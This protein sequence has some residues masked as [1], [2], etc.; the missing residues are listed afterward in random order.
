M[1]E[2]LGAF[3]LLLYWLTVIGVEGYQNWIPFSMSSRLPQSKRTLPSK[4]E[5][6]RTTFSN[7]SPNKRLIDHKNSNTRFLDEKIVHTPQSLLKIPQNEG[8]KRSSAKSSES[9]GDSLMAINGLR[10][11]LRDSMSDGWQKYVRSR[12]AKYR[13]N[14]IY[15]STKRTRIPHKPPSA[16]VQKAKPK[17]KAR[18]AALIKAKNS[19]TTHKLKDI[20]LGRC[21]EYKFTKGLQDRKD[22]E[23]NKLWTMFAKSFMYKP[24]CKP[25]V[26]LYEKFLDHIDEDLPHDRLGLLW[27]G[28]RELAHVIASYTKK[29]V[30][31]EDTLPGYLVNNLT[32]C[33]SEK[34]PG[35]EYKP[36]PW[37]CRIQ[38]D[39]WR[40]ANKRFAKKLSGLVYILLNGTRQHIVDKNIYPAYMKNRYY[41]GPTIIPNLN[42]TNVEKINIVV[43]HS[44]DEKKLESCGEDTVKLL[45][46]D[47]KQLGIDV[48]C[49][50]DPPIILRLNCMKKPLSKQ[51]LGQGIK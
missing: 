17:D 7:D 32:W 27:S 36:C 9:A 19:G 20:F 12:I 46:S 25:S 43:A 15:S 34:S 45:E 30:T 35:I 1:K 4:F 13:R 22:L 6:L 38:K 47:I 31:L 11:G 39:Y 21:H 26:A 33:G 37:E 28:T 42:K 5:S 40:E 23:C 14:K 50:N 48:E 41:L 24:A 44:L 29:Y 16:T 51:C 2:W 18:E 3:L 49:F 8:W 10:T